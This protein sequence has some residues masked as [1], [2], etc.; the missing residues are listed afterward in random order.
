MLFPYARHYSLPFRE[1][2]LPMP[3]RLIEINNVGRLLLSG[4]EY[5][6]GLRRCVGT[7]VAV[8]IILILRTCCEGYTHE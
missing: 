4:R 1:V 8:S 6:V 3:V 7:F 5:K 2:Q